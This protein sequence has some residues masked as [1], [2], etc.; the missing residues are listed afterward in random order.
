MK[1]LGPTAGQL[2]NEQ[3]NQ[4]LE[5]SKR[6]VPMEEIDKALGY[7]KIEEEAKAATNEQE[8]KQIRGRLGAEG[9]RYIRNLG[10]R[11]GPRNQEE[12]NV[13]LNSPEYRATQRK[14]NK[15]AGI[16]KGREFEYVDRVAGYED[17]PTTYVEGLTQGI[18]D[19]IYKRGFDDN[20]FNRTVWRR[21]VGGRRWPDSRRME[22]WQLKQHENAL[23]GELDEYEAVRQQL[24][25]NYQR[26]DPFAR[27][28][29]KEMEK[30]VQGLER[31]R[32]EGR[33]RPLEYLRHM[34]QLADAAKEIKWQYHMKAPGG[35]V[36]D[37]ID[38][39]Q[40]GMFYQRQ[41][42]G[43]MKLHYLSPDYVNQNTKQLDDSTWLVPKVGKEG[44]EWEK[45]KG[46]S[47]PGVD[48]KERE[49]WADK[50]EKYEEKYMDEAINEEMFDSREDAEEWAHQ[51]ALERVGEYKDFADRAADPN[52][53]NP[54]A[55]AAAYMQQKSELEKQAEYERGQV[56]A[57]QRAMDE[58]TRAR[59][60]RKRLVEAVE[61]PTKTAHTRGKDFRELLEQRN[62]MQ[63]QQ[64]MQE[65]K[66]EQWAEQ[67]KWLAENPEYAEYQQRY[68]FTPEWDRPPRPETTRPR[69]E[70]TRP[71]P[72]KKQATNDPMVEFKDQFAETYEQATDER[73]FMHLFNMQ[74][75]QN[76]ELKWLLSNSIPLDV[77]R[78][79]RAGGTEYIKDGMVYEIAEPDGTI[80]K[81]LKLNGQMIMVQEGQREEPV[82]ESKPG[83]LEMLFGSGEDKPQT[84]E[85]TAMQRAGMSI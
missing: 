65:W 26:M 14:F 47:K 81:Y 66:Q 53:E 76:P 50:V 63:H 28:Q 17:R 15:Q 4:L 7:H 54:G 64:A 75:Q 67:E 5:N 77:E 12:R 30:R 10:P 71:E 6:H 78:I 40:N 2:S 31:A 58:M 37:V 70:R 61:G 69:P 68:A 38:K 57:K 36:G 20:I 49:A 32:M 83:I 79:K 73:E 45:V 13:I 23:R 3:L 84:P 41:A 42:D 25:E 80:N 60:Q 39:D 72:K 19:G 9:S 29:Y 46:E 11:M 43:A 21:R 55:D 52:S 24:T 1:E 85:P 48:W 82:A 51:R 27:T 56:E 16:A 74:A 8:A 18:R 35:E 33:V 62:E 59:E 44:V 34:A 22:E